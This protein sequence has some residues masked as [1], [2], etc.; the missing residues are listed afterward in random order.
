MNDDYHI[1]EG[2]KIS[3]ADDVVKQ[4]DLLPE[5]QTSLNNTESVSETGCY[6]QMPDHAQDDHNDEIEMVPQ[7]GNSVGSHSV[8]DYDDDPESNLAKCNSDDDTN[9]LVYSGHGDLD[10]DQYL[11]DV[12]KST[13]S[14]GRAKRAVILVLYVSVYSIFG[15]LIRIIIAQYFGYECDNA[16]ELGLL[17]SVQPLCVDANGKTSILGEIIFADFPANLLGSFLLGFMQS[18]STMNLPKTFPI[19]WLGEKHP[20][21]SY[22]VIHFALNVGFCGSLSSFSA[23]NSDM[24][25]MI[26][27]AD[28]ERGSL[29]F[30]GLLGYFIGIETALASF[31]IGKNLAKYLHSFKNPA[32]Y[33]ESIEMKKQQARG[34][35]INTEVSD[36]ERQF[37][38]EF[39]MAEY[40]IQLSRPNAEQHLKS[41][42]DSTQDARRVGH[43]MLPLLT[44]I[45][46]QAMVLDEVDKEYYDSG[47]NENWDMKALKKWCIAKRE[48]G[49]RIS[50]IEPREF[51][52]LYALNITLLVLAALIL[53][54]FLLKNDGIR[55]ATF[56]E[57]IYASFSAP[58]GSLLRW[59]IS[60]WK[61]K[62]ARLSWFPLGSFLVNLLGCLISTFCIAIDYRMIGSKNTFMIGA[63]RSLKV[64]FAG[65]LSTI[66]LLI[67]EFE[68]MLKSDQPLHGY[69]YICS[70]VCCCCIL[71]AIAFFAVTYEYEPWSEQYYYR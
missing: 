39:D 27:G 34:V 68:R 53:V 65:T 19:A 49:L 13:W 8:L 58:F 6:E 12:S 44:E 70:S 52:F 28:S 56:R 46:Y 57:M 35:Y 69:L 11:S 36:F 3:S 23:L 7:V 50:H 2:D 5:D 15:C 14:F 21:Q 17:K 47:V 45:E 60:T 1:M 43:H 38:S 32:L 24:V 71:S 55:F 61:G 16:G 66:S 48:M 9:L 25:A 20:F 26:I 18:T 67:S 64:G 62:W 10:I 33:K 42:R 40:T 30:R 22:D 4:F 37:L 31:T 41:W 63:F 29:V 54:L 59:K 51:R